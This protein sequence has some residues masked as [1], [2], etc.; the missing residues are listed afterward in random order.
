MKRSI[1]IVL[2]LLI[3]AFLRCSIQVTGVETTNGMV[4]ATIV[5]QDGTPAPNTP[6][7]L[8]PL[9]YDPVK[10]NPF[11]DYLSDTTDENGSCNIIVEKEGS[12]NLLAT[13]PVTLTR[14]FR[15][16]VDVNNDTVVVIDTLKVPGAA[17]I[18]LPDTVDTVTSYLYIPGT[19][20]YERLAEET[21][22]HVD[23]K[24]HV[25]FDSIPAEIIPGL[26]FGKEDPKSRVRKSD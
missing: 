20:L 9:S 12:Y 5:N 2:V 14:S 6:V 23:D 25:I 15:S 22:F 18:E 4:T 1:Y 16:A 10:D 17:K 3:V 21:L 19:G 26:F 11:S 13:H 24:I 8:M 7:F